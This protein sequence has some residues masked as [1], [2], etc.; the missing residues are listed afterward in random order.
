[1]AVLPL[2]KR[3]SSLNSVLDFLRVPAI[4]FTRTTYRQHAVDM[5]RTSSIT[6]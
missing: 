3:E 6:T 5:H 4:L 2:G 1:M